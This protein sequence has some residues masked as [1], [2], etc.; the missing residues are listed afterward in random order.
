[1]RYHLDGGNYFLI[2]PNHRPEDIDASLREAGI[3]VRDMSSK[4]LIEGS[5]RVSIGTTNQMKQFWK[6]FSSLEGII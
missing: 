5:V 2:W 6:V 4:N 1:M 3:L